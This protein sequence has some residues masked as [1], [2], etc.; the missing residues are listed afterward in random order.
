[1]FSVWILWMNSTTDHMVLSFLTSIVTFFLIFV[2]VLLSFCFLCPGLN[3]LTLSIE[4]D[5]HIELWHLY[6][7]LFCYWSAVSVSEG[8]PHSSKGKESACNVGDQGLIP[9]SGR[10]SGEENGKPLQYSCLENAM[11][12]GASRATI[13]VKTAAQ[14]SPPLPLTPPY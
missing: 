14:P 3:W 1:M 6:T 9:G 13:C 8:L 12:R 5:F 7:S 10:S 11:D 4:K 2:S